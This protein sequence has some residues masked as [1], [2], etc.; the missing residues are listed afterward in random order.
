[1]SPQARK[2]RPR[3][4]LQA[5]DHST[6]AVAAPA[7]QDEYADSRVLHEYRKKRMEELRAKATTHVH[8]SVGAIVLGC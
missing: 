5:L 8:G 4:L 3:N 6:A 7:P 2:P 1:M